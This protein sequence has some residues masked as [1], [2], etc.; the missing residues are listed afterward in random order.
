MAEIICITC[1]HV[2]DP[3]SRPELGV[4]DI[5][6]TCFPPP[7][8]CQYPC[9]MCRHPSA[10]RSCGPN[11]GILSRLRR[12]E[13]HHHNSHA[14]IHIA[15]A[16]SRLSP[17]LAVPLFSLPGRCRLEGGQKQRHLGQIL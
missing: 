9:F 15:A 10:Q 6:A 5:L 11:W 7:C 16:S 3:H 13:V 12:L 8:Q 2:S 14:A 4:R 1:G 17:M